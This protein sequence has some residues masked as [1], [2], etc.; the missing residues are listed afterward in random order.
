MRLQWEELTK[1]IQVSNDIFMQIKTSMNYNWNNINIIKKT[2]IFYSSVKFKIGSVLFSK[3]LRYVT[4]A[5]IMVRNM[6]LV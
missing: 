1:T 6:K 5:R 3:I 2:K 4:K